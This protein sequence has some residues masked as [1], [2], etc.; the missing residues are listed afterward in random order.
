MKE[1]PRLE[2]VVDTAKHERE[3]QH[4][5]E[6]HPWVVMELV[7]NRLSYVVSQFSIGS[8]YRA[9]FV[10]GDY[11]SGGWDIHFIE[12]EMPTVRPFNKKGDLSS[13][14][15]HASGQIR[16]WK[17][18]QHRHDKLPGLIA[19]LHD[20]FLKKDLT[21]SDQREPLDSAGKSI[22]WPES[23]IMMHYH[24]VMGRR[25]DLNFEL[26]LRKASL[27]ESDGYQLIT[28]DRIL[29]I[30]S[31][32]RAIIPYDRRPRPPGTRLNY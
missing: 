32:D 2:H 19:Q 26:M 14:L 16:K 18:F 1:A 22:L 24:V 13:K 6:W 8:Q 27:V 7:T 5:L 23:W 30:F 10:V 20:A 28:Y 17:E 12:L 9:D 11:F 3:I 31:Q 25:S 21:W 15:V 4:A 29:E